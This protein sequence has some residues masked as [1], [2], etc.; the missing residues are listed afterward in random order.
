MSWTHPAPQ[1]HAL[2]RREF[3]GAVGATALAMPVANALAAKSEKSRPKV[4]VIFTACFYRSHT[5]NILENFLEPYLFN[6][7]LV[8]PGVEVVSLYGHQFPDNDMAKAMSRQV[9]LPLFDS[10]DRALCLGG[11]ELAVDAVLVIGEHG[12][13]P[14]TSLG[15]TMYPRKEFFD[16]IV[17]VMRRSGRVVP[18]FNDKHLSYRWK[19]AKEMYD[20]SRQMGFPLMAG[21]SVPLSERRPPLDLP[22]GAEIEEAVSIHGGGV[23]SYDFHGAEVL[24]SLVEF[25]PGGET[26]ISQ[27]EFLEGEALKKAGQEGRWSIP[28]AEAAMAAEFGQK[29]DLFGT[30]PGNQ[31]PSQ[32]HGLLL[33]YKDGLRGVVLKVGSNSVR[34]NFAAKRTGMADPWV[35]TFFPGPWGNRNLFKALSHAIQAFFIRGESPY[36]V[37]R[38][39]LTTGV[40]ASA[41]KSRAQRQ[42][43]A[44]PH[45]EFAYS[46]KD[47]SAMR[48]MGGSWKILTEKTP[49]PED[50]RP[51]DRLE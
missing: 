3:L 11:K 7:A 34:W 46:P 44:T 21:S 31:R 28:L 1:A 45:L 12:H 33:T 40:V 43:L 51:G 38:T 30:L 13:Y 29:V 37:E 18:V 9:K 32:P 2:S 6:G 42:P 23:E 50:F 14:Q 49:E 25:R 48:E 22:A 47:F 16:Q 15:Q 4:A 8:D 27:I 19:W 36:P 20:T 10:I 26:G 41:V 5:Y 17:A 39:L 35:T 24:Q